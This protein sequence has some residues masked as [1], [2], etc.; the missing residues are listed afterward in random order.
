MAPIT[1]R[2]GVWDECERF[3][4]LPSAFPLAFFET[5]R[6]LIQKGLSLPT[7]PKIPHREIRRQG[8]LLPPAFNLKTAVQPRI[9]TDGHG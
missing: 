3:I 2:P 5:L 8:A 7:A 1:R 9:D 6:S 4:R